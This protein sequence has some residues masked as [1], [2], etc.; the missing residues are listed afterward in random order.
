VAEQGATICYTRES[1]EGMVE[2]RQRYPGLK[3]AKWHSP[4]EMTAHEPSS[5]GKGKD[6]THEMNIESTSAEWDASSEEGAGQEASSIYSL[7]DAVLL[8]AIRAGDCDVAVTTSYTLTVF[9]SQ[10]EFCDM[11]RL[12]APLVEVRPLRFRIAVHSFLKS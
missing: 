9:E 7:A 4:H 8:D 1:E 12:G 3:Y 11:E 6:E 10:P 5:G 2:M